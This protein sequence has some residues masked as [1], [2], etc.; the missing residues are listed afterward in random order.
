MERFTKEVPSTQ[1][2]QT[3]SFRIFLNCIEG[4]STSTGKRK[5]F[6]T[7]DGYSKA[8]CLLKDVMYDNKGKR[9]YWTI[10]QHIKILTLDER[11][12]FGIMSNEEAW[13]HLLRI[14]M[15]KLRTFSYIVY[16]SAE[17]R[18]IWRILYKFPRDPNFYTFNF[19]L[20]NRVL[21]SKDFNSKDFLHVREYTEADIKRVDEELCRNK[22][23][24]YPSDEQMKISFHTPG[25]LCYL[26]ESKTAYVYSNETPKEM[27][28]RI[29]TEAKKEKEVEKE[30]KEKK[31]QP[32]PKQPEDTTTEDLSKRQ[33]VE[34]TSPISIK[35]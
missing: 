26:K 9:D 13:V 10:L 18:G 34:D 32:E 8:Y 6:V 19:G 27:M 20:K 2:R 17:E 14:Q 3:V 22:R 11:Y 5:F 15:S 31:K 21:A 24:E 28:R 30:G 29:K 4:F 12:W 7:R 25:A 1:N 16:G 33:K 35:N 23:W